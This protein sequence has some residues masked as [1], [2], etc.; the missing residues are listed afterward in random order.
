MDTHGHKNDP[1]LNPQVAIYDNGVGTEGIKL[2]GIVTGVVGWGLSRNIRQLYSELSRVYEPGDNIY[3]FGFSRGAYTVRMLAGLINTYG[4]LKWQDNESEF[5]DLVWK[6]YSRYYRRWLYNQED[7]KAFQQGVGRDIFFRPVPIRFIGVWDTVDAVG[8]PFDWLTEALNCIVQFR[9]KDNKLSDI[10]EQSC[11]ALAIDDE[12]QSFHPVLWNEESETHK[13][14]EQVW[15]SGVHT[16]VGGGYPR[17]GMSLV[18]LD[19]MMKKASMG[20]PGQ[21]GLRFIG[22]DWNVYQEHQDIN[23]KLYNSRAGLAV[24]YRYKPRDIAKFCQNAHTTPKIHISTIE[25]ILQGT[26]GYAPGNLPR[27]FEVVSSRPVGSDL[28]KFIN[29][30][31]NAIH[32][33]TS[34]LEKHACLVRVRVFAYYLFLVFSLLAL[35]GYLFHAE[36]KWYKALGGL[37]SLDGFVSLSEYLM[38]HCWIVVGWIIAVG[39]GLWARLSMKKKFT[40]FWYSIIEKLRSDR[41]EDT[42]RVT[43]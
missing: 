25:R 1:E 12:R 17:Q 13:K 23:D 35:G 40:A 30:F 36:E 43:S 27:D 19:W 20:K 34:L 24:Y 4:L 29:E 33:H 3:L 14:I 2:I 9:F 31:K 7:I 10:V 11:Q 32:P 41:E 8:L 37:F 16:N 22:H 18:S 38:N 5:M 15:F 6:A 42:N 26:D 21:P 28:A 39:I